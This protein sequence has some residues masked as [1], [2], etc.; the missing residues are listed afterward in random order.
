MEQINKYF[1]AEKSE[2]LIFNWNSRNYTLDLFLNKNKTTILHWNCLS[3]NC[4]CT[5]SIG[6]CEGATEKN[7]SFIHRIKVA[8]E[9]TI[10]YFAVIAVT[11][12]VLSMTIFVLL[13]IID[14]LKVIN[15]INKKINE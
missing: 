12:L 11:A 5:H 4:N 2:S 15:A 10:K 13:L 7:I 9:W 3:F 14:K 1:N 6:S 8:L